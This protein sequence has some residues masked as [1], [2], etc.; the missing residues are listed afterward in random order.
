MDDIPEVLWD[1]FA[2]IVPRKM[3]LAEGII[4]LMAQKVLEVDRDSLDD[5]TRDEIEQI[6]QEITHGK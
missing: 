2:E 1:E 6:I 4:V 5:Q 3:T